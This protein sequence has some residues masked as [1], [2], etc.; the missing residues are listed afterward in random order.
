MGRQIQYLSH[1]WRIG[2]V[3][4]SLENCRIRT[5]P[6]W[7]YAHIWLHENWWKMVSFAASLPYDRGKLVL[8]SSSP[9][10]A[11][12]VPSHTSPSIKSSPFRVKGYCN[13]CTYLCICVCTTCACSVCYNS[14]Y[15]SKFWCSIVAVHV[16]LHVSHQHLT[17][18]TKL[19][20]VCTYVRALCVMLR[21]T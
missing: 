8:L 10:F 11:R 18:P 19:N 2:A 20:S 21:V 3:F 4:P 12:I 9:Q 15:L 7:E 14:N 5:K 6:A 16:V 17:L 13:A 1:A